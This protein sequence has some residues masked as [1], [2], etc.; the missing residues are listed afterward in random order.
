MLCDGVMLILFAPCFLD[1]AEAVDKNENPD[2]R[3][4]SSKLASYP[5]PSGFSDVVKVAPQAHT[6]HAFF[7][8]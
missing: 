1:S 5:R 2:G 6:L 3:W 8:V 7:S 4:L